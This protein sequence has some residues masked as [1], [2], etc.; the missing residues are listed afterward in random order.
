M[1]VKNENDRIGSVLYMSKFEVLRVNGCILLPVR[2]W[3]K[4]AYGSRQVGQK[5]CLFLTM[6]PCFVLA[7][8]IQSMMAWAFLVETT[9]QNTRRVDRIGGPLV[10]SRQRLEHSPMVK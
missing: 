10:F 1:T 3:T 8:A 4:A 9:Y 5:R 7:E 2:A 6:D